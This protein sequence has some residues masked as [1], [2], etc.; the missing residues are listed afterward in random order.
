MVEAELGPFPTIFTACF[1]AI[2]RRSGEGGE[3]SEVEFASIG[4]AQVKRVSVQ[5]RIGW[6]QKQIVTIAQSS[7]DGRFGFCLC[8]QKNAGMLAVCA[9]EIQTRPEGWV[10]GMHVDG[11]PG[12]VDR[13]PGAEMD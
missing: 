8:Q 5:K 11:G 2:G 7:D 3:S 9:D 1:R 10:L 13:L 12:P 4:R 6:R